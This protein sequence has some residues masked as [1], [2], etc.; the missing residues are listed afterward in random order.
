MKDRRSE[1]VDAL[2]DTGGS[3]TDAAVR[4]GIRE[5]SLRR[6]LRHKVYCRQMEGE[7]TQEHAEEVLRGLCS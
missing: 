7:W 6:Y 3:V 4:L 5:T 1:I 2:V